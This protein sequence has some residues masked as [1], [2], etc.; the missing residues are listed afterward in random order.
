M[1][2]SFAT[3]L[4]FLVVVPAVVALLAALYI[5]KGLVVVLMKS[6]GAR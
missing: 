2:T 6:R 5:G 4:S 3:R 1:R